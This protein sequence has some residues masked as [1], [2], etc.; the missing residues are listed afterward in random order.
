MEKENSMGKVKETYVGEKMEI[1]S[2]PL[3]DVITTSGESTDEGS[4]GGDGTGG[5]TGT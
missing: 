2:F 5:W 4:L 1:I 3:T